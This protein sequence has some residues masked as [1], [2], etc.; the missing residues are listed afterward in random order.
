MTSEIIERARTLDWDTLEQLAAV[1]REAQKA[2]GPDYLR[3][4]AKLLVLPERHDTMTSTAEALEEATLY[5]ELD[6][7]RTPV[8][9]NRV[10]GKARAAVRWAALAADHRRLLS[11]GEFDIL[12]RAWRTVVG[13][14]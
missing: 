9:V 13:D 6:A 7:D 12:T 3:G 4:R 2:E 10:L 11:A 8:M 1:Q 5:L 14:I